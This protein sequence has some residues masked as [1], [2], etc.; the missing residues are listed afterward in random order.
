MS[1]SPDTLSHDDLPPSL[2]SL[3]R[4]V[5][6]GYRSEPRLLVAS[7]AMAL[8]AAV[9]D[10]LVALWIALLADGV[11]SD[12]PTKVRVA[13]VG[14]A[15]SAVGSWYMRVLFDRVQRRFRDKVS[16]ALESHVAHLQAS[17]ATIEHQE[18]PEHLDR[19][20]VLRDQVFALDHMFLSL[21]GTVG[22]FL[23]LGFTVVLLMSV[24]ASLGL[25][26]V[27]AVPILFTAT[28]RPAVERVVEESVAPHDR[29]ARHVF[30][31]GTTAPAGKEVRLAGIGA[32]LT[33][34]R[35]DEWG[36]WYAPMG[37]V[38]WRT[39]AW[40]AAA[41]A[42][43]GLGYVGAIVYVAKGLDASEAAVLLVVVSGGRLSQY[44]AAAVG[45]LSFLRGVWLDSARR[46]AWLEDY[47]ASIDEDADLS[48]RP[49]SPTASGSTT[50]RS[51]TPAPSGS[52][53]RTSSCT[54]RPARWWPSSARTAPA[55]RR[56]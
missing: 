27:L 23:R 21:F 53:S 55:R 30:T 51:A 39:A 17:V 2:S 34:D 4:M 6:L 40:H 41:W 5:K 3:W 16:V 1:R 47:A 20:S 15:A 32:R 26:V 29:Q 18:R 10:T 54:S 43:F 9:P 46:L 37:A 35:A 31:L 56:W 44:V 7:F 52:C 36:Q 22:W 45:E 14:L 48:P 12:E 50:S 13:V 8:F 24:H 11:T 42:I 25:I 19:L 38:R 28:W 33:S 49:G